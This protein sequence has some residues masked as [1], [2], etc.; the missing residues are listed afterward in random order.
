VRDDARRLRD[1]LRCNVLAGEYPDRFL[2]SENE[3]MAS[4]GMPRAAVREAL[5]MLR[6]E[7]VIERVQGLGTFATRERYVT[8]LSLI[9]GERY[10]EDLLDA[11]SRPELLD[12]AIIPAPDAVAR[13]LELTR[14]EDV[15]RIE[16]VQYVSSEPVAVVT[17]FVTFPEAALIGDTPFDTEWYSLLGQAGVVVG[18]SEWVFDCVNADPVIAQLLG[19]ASG[20]AIMLGEQVIWHADGRPCDFGINYV[21][22]DRYVLCSRVTR[23][24]GGSVR[25]LPLP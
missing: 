24:G 10:R 23:D 4:F 5:A 7:G 14:G 22:T 3:L 20:T 1:L 6:S 13:K 11:H 8:R 16:Y 25:R 12:Q 15:L 17:K 2:P 19:V 18:D 9:H 21:R